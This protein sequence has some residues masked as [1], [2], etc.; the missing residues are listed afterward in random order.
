MSS[1]YSNTRVELLDYFPSSKGM[2]VLELGCGE[3]RLG[4]HLKELGVASRVVGIELDPAAAA[5]A[6]DVLDQVHC[7]NLDE[8][9]LTLKEEFDLLVCADVIEHLRDPRKIVDRCL[10]AVKPGGFVLTSTPNVRNWRVLKHIIV[11]GDFEY[12]DSG[13]MDRTHLRWFTSKSIYRFHEE[14]ELRV[15]KF[16]NVPLSGKTQLLDRWTFGQLREF[17]V[18]QHVVLSQKP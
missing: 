5:I 14:L 17:L 8:T 9:E 1:Y 12:Q 13:L 10:S 6:S 7:A 16:G 3:G 4:S 2:S 15:I 11:D 18:G